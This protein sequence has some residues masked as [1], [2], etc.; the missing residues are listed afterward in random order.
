[1]GSLARPP[2]I[3]CH[4]F[5]N[6]IWVLMNLLFDNAGASANSGGSWWKVSKVSNLSATENARNDCWDRTWGNGLG[7]AG[8]EC[9]SAGAE[10]S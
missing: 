7:G 1:M 2:H 9:A 6:H 4:N 3:A 5:V 10:N 8:I